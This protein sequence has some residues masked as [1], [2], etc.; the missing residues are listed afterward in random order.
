MGLRE[1]RQV[2]FGDV[3][4]GFVAVMMTILCAGGGSGIVEH[5]ACPNKGHSASIW[6]TIL[7]QILQEMEDFEL[8]SLLRCWFYVFQ[9]YVQGWLRVR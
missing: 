1:I 5:P 2:I 3:L 8:I 4:L 6:K 9:P 7:F